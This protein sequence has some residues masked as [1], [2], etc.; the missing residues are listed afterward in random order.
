MCKEG[1]HMNKEI[2]NAMIKQCENVINICSV[3]IQTRERKL[4]NSMN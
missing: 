3:D 2:I 4:A 1:I